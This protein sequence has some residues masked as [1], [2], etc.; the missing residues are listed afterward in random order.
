MLLENGGRTMNLF[1]G[2]QSFVN[3]HGV[4]HYF[5]RFKNN[6]IVC[7]EPVEVQGFSDSSQKAICKVIHARTV[8]KDELVELSI[9]DD[10]SPEL[11]EQIEKTTTEY[12]EEISDKMAHA[13]SKKRNKFKDL[14]EF[15]K[16]KCGRETK[17]NYSY[18][19]KKADKMVVPLQTLIDGYQCQKCNPTK[20]R[21]KR[22][23]PPTE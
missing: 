4:K 8:P 14:P 16:C 2:Y 1:E 9:W 22:S 23:N 11:Q 17:A 6:K 10:L 18:L 7:W 5:V 3:N 21:H 13:R 19:Q 12:R 20:G 15:L